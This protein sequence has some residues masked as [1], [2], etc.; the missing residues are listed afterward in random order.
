MSWFSSN[1]ETR[2]SQDLSGVPIGQLSVPT[3]GRGR[4]SRSPSPAARVG[5]STF[6]P[7]TSN[8]Y[9]NTGENM[10]ADIDVAELQRIAKSAT[11]AA[12]AAAAA[13]A[14][15]TTQLTASQQANSQLRAIKKPELPNFD[16]KNIKIWI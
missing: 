4:G 6:F 5:N 9:R 13:L 11:D 1:R 12:S 10:L 2:A 3:R 16:G 15:M 7:E 14:A 8:L